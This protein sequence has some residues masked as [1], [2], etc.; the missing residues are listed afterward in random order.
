MKK[1]KV[2]KPSFAEWLDQEL[3]KP[4]CCE[5]C[6]LTFAHAKQIYDLYVDFVIEGKPDNRLGD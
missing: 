4:R 5:K 3:K 1:E 2:K 6:D